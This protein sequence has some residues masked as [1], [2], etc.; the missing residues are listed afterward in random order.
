MKNKIRSAFILIKLV[1][2]LSCF[3]SFLIY[4]WVSGDKAV[5][6]KSCCRNV[7]KTT[8]QK[9]KLSEKR[10]NSTSRSAGKRPGKRETGNGKPF[11]KQKQMTD[12]HQRALMCLPDRQTEKRSRRQKIHRPYDVRMLLPERRC[13]NADAGTMVSEC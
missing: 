12:P 9:R 8:E 4:L 1:V 11:S 13:Q 5:T 6:P 10:T 7:L 3:L 2:M